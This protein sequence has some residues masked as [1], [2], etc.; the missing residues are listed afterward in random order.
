VDVGLGYTVEEVEVDW[1]CIGDAA[2]QTGVLV[3]ALAGEGSGRYTG[4]PPLLLF[5]YLCVTFGL[6]LAELLLASSC[7]LPA[8]DG[9]FLSPAGL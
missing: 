3:S 4:A 2:F 7:W 5:L 8:L 9:A 6:W 1:C